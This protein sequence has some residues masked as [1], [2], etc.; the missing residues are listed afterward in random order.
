MKLFV[1]D[2][3]SGLT[4]QDD[5][6]WLDAGHLAALAHDLMGDGYVVNTPTA[7]VDY[8]SIPPTLT[9]T[10]PV[11][12]RVPDTDV[13]S[14]TRDSEA[15]TTWPLGAFAAVYDPQTV[16]LTDST[17]NHVYAVARP[18]GGLPDDGE[19]VV[20]DDGAGEAPPTDPSVLIHEV[21]TTG[22]TDTPRSRDPELAGRALTVTGDGSIGGALDVTGAL[23][24]NGTGVTLDSRF[25][26]PNSDLANSSVT[27]AGNAVGLGGST[28]VAS[29]QLSDA[30][31]LAYADAAEAISADWTFVESLTQGVDPQD[32]IEETTSP[33][34][35]NFDGSTG[36]DIHDY[37]SVTLSNATAASVTE[38]IT[39]ELYDG[40]DTTGALMQSET[41][42][43]TVGSGS[44]TTVS[45]LATD[46]P[47][48]LG[49][50]HIEVTQSGV[51]LT[52][53]KTAEQTE[54][55][56]FTFGQNAFGV[57]SLT[58]QAGLDAL[59]VDPINEDVQIISGDLTNGSSK[60]FD[61][62]NS[63]VPTSILKDSSVTVA[64]NAVGLGG[65]TP[66]A[67][68]D[69]STIGASDHHARPV[70]GNGLAEG[71]SNDFNVDLVV[72]GTVTLSSGT[73]TVAT[74]VTTTPAFFTIYLDPSGAGLNAADVKASAR[75][76]WD[77]TAGEYKV[78][79]LEDGTAVGTPDIGYK[80]VQY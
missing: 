72:E 14:R 4:N 70:A 13:S 5:R 55:A 7:T 45:F 9:Y 46:Q 22:G 68:A 43:V 49:T 8:G 48:D 44:T 75:A 20:V 21:D 33:K 40:I 62:T 2:G 30:A 11:Q 41:Q 27:V 71:A 63:W 73:A 80:V 35:F 53:D 6:D 25:P 18:T 37:T 23:T 76:Y 51:D 69:L 67:H 60:I 36:R 16:S 31:S 66:V 1:Q 10:D 47:L 78:E 32:R 52:V 19:L 56:A 28:A 77:N 79:I 15:A 54:G 12:I 39:V 64:G 3:G 58:T 26:L 42:S 61:G 29:T 59:R 38:D 65:S 57:L 17:T 74:G 24:E 50:Y 34:S